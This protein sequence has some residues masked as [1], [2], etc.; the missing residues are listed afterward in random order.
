MRCALSELETADPEAASKLSIE[1]IIDIRNRVA[2]EMN[3]MASHGWYVAR[4][5]DEH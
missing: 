5:A 3:H 2:E 1:K 4:L